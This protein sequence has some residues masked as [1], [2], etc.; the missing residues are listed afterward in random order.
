MKRVDANQAEIVATLRA[1]G[2]S[3]QSLAELGKGVPDLLVGFRR[4]NYLMEVKSA[5][6]RL[7]EA[8]QKWHKSWRGWVYVVHSIEEALEAVR[9]DL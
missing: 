9:G 6:G 4:E 3:V 5:S 7:T 1:R 2:C 8:E